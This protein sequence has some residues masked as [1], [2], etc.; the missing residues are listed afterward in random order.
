[1]EVDIICEKR[2]MD[3]EELIN[4]LNDFLNSVSYVTAIDI[5]NI[6]LS[7]YNDFLKLVHEYNLDETLIRFNDYAVVVLKK[8]R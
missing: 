8:W 3:R 4:Y 7:D 1:M 5:S 2:A 6:T